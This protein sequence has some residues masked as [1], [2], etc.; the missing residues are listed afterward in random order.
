MLL[1][2]GLLVVLGALYAIWRGVDVRLALLLAALLLGTMAGDLAVI[3]RTFFATFANERFVVPI[4]SAMGFAYVLKHTQCDAHLVHVLLRPLLKVRWLLIPSTVVVGFLINIPIVSQT[5]SAVT[6]GA[7]V[8]PILRAAR[9]SPATTGAA[10]LLGCSMGGE[11]LNPGAPELPTVVQ[12][13][14]R[15]A[16]ELHREPLN[17]SP[18]DIVRRLAP[19]NVLG[20]VVAVLVF[21]WLSSR[22][23]AR[24]HRLDPVPPETPAPAE[25]RIHWLKAAVPLVP[26]LLLF[27]TGEPFRLIEV[28]PEWLVSDREKGFFGSRLVGAAMMVG[29]LAA[30]LVAWRSCWQVPRVFFDGAGYGF[31]NIISL[32]VT[33]NCFGEGMKLIG[34]ARLVEQVV[35]AEEG[36]LLPLAGF[37][38]LTFA[39]C[40]GSGIAAT[41][42]LFGLFARPALE[43]GIDP[44]LVGSVV[45]LASAAGR[46]MSPVAAV[47]L[48]CATLSGTSSFA[49]VRRVALP[50]LASLTVIVLTALALG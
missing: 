8:M 26:L 23:E 49:L 20:L 14:E 15:A 1:G 27:L 3:V 48:M 6:L 10:L 36:L 37:L 9:I 25:F 44:T 16:R 41:Q 50:L 22:S 2:L 31:A 42:S 19:F 46:T 33:A 28:P 5:S 18:T 17:L 12:E 13:S 7:V 40:T 4:C 43:L 29:V 34:L 24:D 21:W 35:A 39:V 32:I 11:L 30:G 38:P 45:T 47:A